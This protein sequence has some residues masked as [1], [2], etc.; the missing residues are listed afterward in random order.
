LPQP[1]L[2]GNEPLGEE[3]IVDVLGVD[4]RHAPTVAQN[5]DLGL[6]ARELDLSL[7]LRQRCRCHGVRICHRS[8]FAGAAAE[9]ETGHEQDDGK[10]EF[11]Q[12]WLS[13]VQHSPPSEAPFS[14]L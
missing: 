11:G 12:A 5:F 9:G 14:A 8:L 2:G 1:V 6:Q 10:V 13:R 7:E 3:E 4:V